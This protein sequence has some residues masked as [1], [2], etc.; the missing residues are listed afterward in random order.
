VT[1]SAR[2]LAIS[3]WLSR[4]PRP[5]R[6]SA[7]LL[8]VAIALG[9][10]LGFYLYYARMT[11]RQLQGGVFQ[12][13]ADVYAA[14]LVFNEGDQFSPTE[15]ATA[16][17]QAGFEES[18][19]HQQRTYRVGP[20]AIEIC[21]ATSRGGPDV[22]IAFA[23]NQKIDQITTNGGRAKSWSAGIP[24]ITTLTASEED[25]EGG[26]TERQ[27]RRLVSFRDIPQTLVDAVVSGEDKHFFE[28][29]GIDLPR[30]AMATWIDFREG[31][32]RQGGSTLTM[33]LV[34]GL[35]LEPEKRF[36]RKAAE[37]MMTVHLERK[38]SKEQI[39]E[40]YANQVYLGRQNAYGIHGF[41]EGSR[42]FFNKQ[43]RDITLPEAALLAG[44]VQR[45][46]YFN[47]FRH[48]ERA[49]DRRDVI[50][51]LMRDNGRITAPQ[52]QQALATEVRLGGPP[53]RDDSFGAPYFL[54]L[55]TDEMKK[56]H[57][58]D[59]AGPKGGARKVFT[60][61]DLN[62]QRAASESLAV[63]MKEVDA[64]LAHAANAKPGRAEAALIAIDPHTGEIKALVGGRNYA[65][66]QLNRIIANRPPG[67]VFKPFVYAAALNTGVDGGDKVFTSASVVDD[68]PT[69]F[70]FAGKPYQ[71]ANYHQEWFGTLTLKQAL[72]K[73]DNIAAVKVAEQVGYDAVVAMAKGAGL[74]D[75][76]QATPSVA[77]GSYDVTPLEMAGAWTMFANGGTVL[78]PHLV[79]QVQNVDGERLRSVTGE[80]HQALDP[81]VAYLML[82]M[83]QEV[84]R[85][86]TGAGVRSRGFLLPSAGKTGT[87]HDG[88]FAGFT[89]QL[90]CLVWVGFDDYRELNLEGA[91]SALPIWTEFMKKAAHFAPYRNATE[92]PQP[93]GGV[94][95]TTI[96][97]ETGQVASE[98]CPE[99][100]SD[101]FI[102]GTQP[103][104][105]CDLH[106]F[107]AGELIGQTN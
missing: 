63:A 58:D 68:S 55:V 75:R 41:A 45:P 97:R 47:P 8:L 10:T 87:S 81:R 22:H 61:L 73:S 90:L 95:A 26:K 17:H 51:A 31:R 105:R 70:W 57:V 15:L 12:N 33:Q 37:I 11:D 3:G 39:F 79:T 71:P 78:K 25:D 56:Q 62:L 34:R 9:G 19:L 6:A 38:W 92:F 89:S 96:C 100:R 94:V 77:L 60:T 5:S 65:E 67:S 103:Q 48:P 85:S 29:H 27:K 24:L 66:S 40:A 107:A 80:P 88:W 74:N 20:S 101:M 91:K 16:L 52:Y 46:S 69:T 23:A 99:V 42:L 86:G 13:A 54:D 76:I 84:M 44:L 83:L 2:R 4:R 43:L 30:I 53:E 32:K 93:P 14:P 36:T 7:L 104:R 18:M 106:D 28:H 72:A 59:I 64:Q 50:L 21:S 49:K 98:F 1:L 35:W 102:S 82:G